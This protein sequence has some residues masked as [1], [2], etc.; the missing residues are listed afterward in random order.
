MTLNLTSDIAAG[1]TTIAAARGLSVEDYL[2]QIVEDELATAQADEIP[3]KEGSGMVLENG[4]LIYGAGTALPT[5][6]VD[7]AI[8]RSRDERSHH[9]LGSLS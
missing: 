9:L 2:R 8:R 1:L 7:N 3:G 4:L 5:A 6:V